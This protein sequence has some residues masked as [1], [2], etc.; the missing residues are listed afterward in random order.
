MKGEVRQ[1]LISLLREPVPDLDRI[2]PFFISR[3]N[4][5]Y[6]DPSAL[7]WDVTKEDWQRYEFLGD[8]VLSLT[9]AQAL[10][11]HHDAILSEGAMTEILAGIVSNRTLG[12]LARTHPSFRLLVPLAFGESVV[13]GDRIAAGAFEAF[14]GALYCEIGFDDVAVF[15]TALFAGQLLACV[16]CTN[17]KG[18]LQE[19]FQKRG[20]HPPVYSEKKREGPDH[21]PLFAV[22]V[23]LNDGRVFEGSG[24]SL[25]EAERMAAAAALDYIRKNP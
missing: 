17:P 8:R 19:Y 24:P 6:G 11:V 15:L 23:R 13:Y 5:V 25:A 10:F 4:A 16:P 22:A 3:Y 21:R 12:A 1:S 2:I 7:R 14:V 9:I 18:L 20:F